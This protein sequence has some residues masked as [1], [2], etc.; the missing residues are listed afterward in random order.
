MPIL[1]DYMRASGV[2]LPNMKLG[3]IVENI[4]L[5]SGE[6]AVRGKGSCDF[7]ELNRMFQEK[8]GDLTN[9]LDYGIQ[10]CAVLKW[11]FEKTEWLG[12]VV[13]IAQQFSIPLT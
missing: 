6:Q 8:R 1:C 5:S 2:H 11:A 7:D 12:S 13:A 4:P 3:T 9:V 10:D